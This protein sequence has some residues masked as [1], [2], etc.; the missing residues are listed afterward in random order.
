MLLKE[1]KREYG[2]GLDKFEPNDINN[3]KM[4]DILTISD[5]DKC[6]IL[7]LYNQIRDMQNNFSIIIENLNNIF[8][9][10][11]F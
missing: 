5:E 1:C 7:S 6:Q 4:L 8:I 9:S 10:Y 11:M 3:A 2:G